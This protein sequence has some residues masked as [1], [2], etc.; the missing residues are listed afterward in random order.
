M[1]FKKQIISQFALKQYIH[2][3]LFCKIEIIWQKM[4]EKCD[5]N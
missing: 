4:L 3:K 2:I 5:K 1:N